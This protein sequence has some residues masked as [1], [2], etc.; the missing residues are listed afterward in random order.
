M[1]IF[2]IAALAGFPLLPAFFFINEVLAALLVQ[3]VV[4]GLLAALAELLIA[5]GAARI[6]FTL[7]AQARVPA[8]QKTGGIFMIL[9]L[10][11]LTFSV[12]AMTTPPA[13]EFFLLPILGELDT[14]RSWGWYLVTAGI[15]CA[16]AGMGYALRARPLVRLSKV[17]EHIAKGEQW[18]SDRLA[19]SLTTVGRWVYTAEEKLVDRPTR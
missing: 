2:G 6:V 10:A 13:V 12:F 18:L 15:V 16:G 19:R 14:V 5:F 3:Q 9:A 7:P 4:L 17:W 11:V 8:T 1:P